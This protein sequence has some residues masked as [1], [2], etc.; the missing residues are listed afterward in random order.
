M[1]HSSSSQQTI[2]PNHHAEE[3]DDVHDQ[4]RLNN[5]PSQTPPIPYP[6]PI[7]PI[8]RENA[9]VPVNQRAALH[10]ETRESLNQSLLNFFILNIVLS[11]IQ[12]TNQMTMIRIRQTILAQ[13]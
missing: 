12:H 7:S 2:V 4:S 11:K 10:P 5:S 9:T 6:A 3:G 8:S 1:A 13:F